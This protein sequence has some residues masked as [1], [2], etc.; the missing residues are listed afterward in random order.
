MTT[1]AD[2]PDWLIDVECGTSIGD[3]GYALGWMFA[4]DGEAW[5]LVI[6]VRQD[7][8]QWIACRPHHFASVAPHELTGPLPQHFGL[9]RCGAPTIAGRP[10]RALVSS[11]GQRCRH[12]RGGAARPPRPRATTQLALF[13][14][15]EAEAR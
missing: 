3:A 6:D 2:D 1:S 14:V 7:E 9:A 4:P 5:P 11:L 12:H 8:P 13:D 15:P 10:C